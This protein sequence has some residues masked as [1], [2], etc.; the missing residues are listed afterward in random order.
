MEDFYNPSSGG[1]APKI[2]DVIYLDKTYGSA[3]NY[4]G[5]K[6]PVG[7][8]SSVSTDGRDVTIINLRF[9][10]LH[11]DDDDAEDPVYYFDPEHPYADDLDSGAAYVF[12]WSADNYN[13]ISDDY[14]VDRKAL[15]GT[16]RASDNCPCQFYKQKCR[17]NELICKANT[18]KGFNAE[19][20]KCI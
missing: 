18:G 15:E 20:C 7:V 2:G 4:N 10:T 1:T 6:M 5:S 17:L 13:Y 9:L 19:T 3:T 8:I 12:K 16:A 14:P 11:S